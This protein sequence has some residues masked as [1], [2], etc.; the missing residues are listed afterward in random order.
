MNDEQIPLW[1]MQ[2]YRK[3][4]RDSVD[5]L[6]RHSDQ[7][8]FF[9]LTQGKDVV[10]FLKMFRDDPDALMEHGGFAEYGAP[11][12]CLSKIE[13]VKAKMRIEQNGNC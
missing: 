13:K 4:L 9:H 7:M 11:K 3:A 6:E 2:F 12:D 5:W 10:A 8:K 1:G